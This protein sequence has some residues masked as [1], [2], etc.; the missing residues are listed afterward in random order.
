MASIT[1]TGIGSSLDV[2]SII[3]GL[4]EIE[5]SPIESL[6]AKQE[7]YESQIS[8]YGYL[9]D[10]LIDF[11]DAIESLSNESTFNAV[12]ASIDDSDVAS[13]TVGSTASK[14]T[15]DLEVTSLAQSQKLVA[16]GQSDTTTA[17]GN[18]TIS[19]DFGT[20]V[21]GTFD[22]S[23]GHYTDSAFNSNGGGIQTITIDD[24]NNS[25]AGICDTINEAD[26]GVTASLVNDG[27]DTP[28]RLVLSSENS[29]VN[30]TI[31]I[32]VT[33]ESGSTALSSLLAHD[34]SGTQNLSETVQAENAEFILDGITISKQTNTVSD[35]IEG[36]TFDLKSISEDGEGTKVRVD[37]DLT[38]VSTAITGFVDAYNEIQETFDNA[39]AFDED[40]GTASVLNGDSTVRTLQTQIRDFFNTPISAATTGFSMLSDIGI[41]FEKDGMLSLDETKLSS[42][43]ENNFSDVTALFADIS[44]TSDS[45]IKTNVATGNT[46]EGTYDVAVTQLAT[47]GSLLASGAAELEIIAG[48]N[49]TLDVTLDGNTATITLTAGIYAT[50]DK[51]ASEMQSKINGVPTFFDAESSVDVSASNGVISIN[52]DRYGSGSNISI[53]G[54]S[55]RDDLFLGESATSTDGLDVEGTINGV[56]ARGSGQTLT[57]ATGD[58]SE[59]LAIDIIGGVVG[60]RG[61]VTYSKGFAFQLTEYLSAFTDDEVDDSI[62]TRITGLKES[63]SRWDD[64]IEDLEARMVVI[65]ARYRAE[66]TALDVLMSELT[67]TSDYLTQMLDSLNSSSD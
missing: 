9:N 15:Y 65:E 40:E 5:R 46:V 12:Y 57:G 48:V 19:I 11:Y 33:D 37:Y 10:A 13:I 45:L 30:N 43:L 52:S 63:I 44:R 21:G 49:D 50:A 38:T 34:P 24:S 27:S 36:V 58:D 35:A 3:T 16:S 14:A 31:K 6:E 64:D 23:T 59:G 67:T 39:M 17:I 4:M 1:S 60:D 62:A 53:T 66:Y 22:E 20:I 25:L 7:S 47:T 54:G 32:D 26:I 51:L 56:E 29:G 55:A 2:E 8:A 18:G 41:S 42:A 61:T 28:Y